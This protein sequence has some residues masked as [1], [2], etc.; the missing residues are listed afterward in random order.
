MKQLSPTILL[1]LITTIS[2]GQ[3]NDFDLKNIKFNGLEFST[4]KEK[5][6]KLFGAVKEID[7]NYECGFFAN[8]QDGGPYYQLAYTG[9]DYIGSDG[10]KFY[11]QHVNF[12]KPGKTRIN[13]KNQILSG[14]T[15]K[16]N[17]IKM[18]GHIAREHFA[19]NPGEQSILLYSKGSDDGAVFTFEDNRLVKFQYWTPC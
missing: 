14:Q 3:E 5:I 8:D 15:T 7:T 1:L 6:F 10:G 4:T 9:F 16:D 18:F 12:D 19:N 17:F 13:Y 11:L 2:Y